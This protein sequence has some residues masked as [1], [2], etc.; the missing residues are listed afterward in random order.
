MGDVAAL[1]DERD[2]WHE[3]VNASAAG[4]QRARQSFQQCGFSGAVAADERGY[5]SGWEACRDVIERDVIAVCACEISDAEFCHSL[6][7]TVIIF[8]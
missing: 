1:G 2:F 3:V 6:M 8:K 5:S 7:I 4:C